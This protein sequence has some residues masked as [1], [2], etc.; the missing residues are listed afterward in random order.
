LLLLYASGHA[1][2]ADQHRRK[3]RQQ[4]LLLLLLL[5]LHQLLR[6]LPG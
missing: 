3:P 6:V 1:T 4:W 2:S 5:Q